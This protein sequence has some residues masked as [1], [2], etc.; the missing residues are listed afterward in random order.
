MLN[1]IRVWEYD[2]ETDEST[3]ESGPF[4]FESVHQ[5]ILELTPGGLHTVSIVRGQRRMHLLGNGKERVF[6]RY[7][8][9]DMNLYPRSKRLVPVEGAMN[10][11][12]L[13]TD[14]GVQLRYGLEPLE[15]ISIAEHFHR[16]GVE[17]PDY[18]WLPVG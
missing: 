4:D 18:E 17:H 12:W 6:I 9:P 8:K 3:V 14:F 11:L 15:S 10:L 2:P 7:Y 13:G 16:T 1:I 5:W